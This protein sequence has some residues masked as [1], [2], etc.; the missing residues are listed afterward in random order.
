[1]HGGTVCEGRLG[2]LLVAVARELSG[3]GVDAC[4]WGSGRR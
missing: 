2:S 1:M 4:V 3:W